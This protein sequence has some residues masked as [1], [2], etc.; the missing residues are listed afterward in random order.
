VAVLQANVPVLWPTA[1]TGEPFIGFT[2]TVI[3]VP[4]GRFE[5]CTTMGIGLACW[6]DSTASGVDSTPVGEAETGTPA[7]LM[8]VI[9]GNW[10]VAGMMTNCEP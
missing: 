9:C 1:L 5:H 10:P 2:L 6:A 8:T 4:K 7:T 3:G